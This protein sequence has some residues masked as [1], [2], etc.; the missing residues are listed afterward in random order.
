MQLPISTV[1]M[2]AWEWLAGETSEICWRVMAFKNEDPKIIQ[3]QRTYEFIWVQEFIE[4]NFTIFSID[5]L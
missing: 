5:D 3:N 2:A 1:Q 4:R